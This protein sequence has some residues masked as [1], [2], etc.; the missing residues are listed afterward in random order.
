MGRS[1]RQQYCAPRAGGKRGCRESS[2]DGRQPG[3]ADPAVHD[4]IGD[5]EKNQ[6]IRRQNKRHKIHDIGYAQDKEIP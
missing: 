4:E 3:L 6:K 1:R 2:S 5:Y